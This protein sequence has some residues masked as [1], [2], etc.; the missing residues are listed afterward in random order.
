M[1]DPSSDRSARVVLHHD[2]GRAVTAVWLVVTVATAVTASG[3]PAADRPAW[4]AWMFAVAAALVAVGWLPAL[5]VDD[6]AVTVVNPLRTHRIPWPAV[7]DVTVGWL[8]EVT[9]GTAR[10]RSLAV[11]GPRRMRALWERHATGYGVMERDGV[12]ALQSASARGE[13]LIGLGD[14]SILVAQRWAARAALTPPGPVTASWSWPGIVALAVAALFAVL[15]V[16][17]VLLG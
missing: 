3:R 11:P 8:L 2:L 16:L 4:A 14:A 6:D 12:T 13:G 17:A 7:D 5:V 10:Y 9:A 1:R 15:A